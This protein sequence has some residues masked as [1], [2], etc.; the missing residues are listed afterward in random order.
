M[1]W[2]AVAEKDFR[3]A[4]RSRLLL[5]VAGLFVL[6]TVGGA[7]IGSALGMGG[8]DAVGLIMF[9]MLSATGIF[10][11]II[12]IGLSYR[13]IAGER[14]TGS[15]KI[16]LSLPNSRADVVLGKFAG[17]SAVLAVT[18]IV[19]FT[20][21]L[22]AFAAAFEGNVEFPTYAAFMLTTLLLGFVFVSITVG[23]SAFTNS[24][25]QSAVGAVGL[26]VVF[27]WLWNILAQIAWYVENGFE[28]PPFQA[29]PPDWLEF[30]YILNPTVSYR[31]A[32]SWLVEQVGN[33]DQAQQSGGLE[34]FGLEP[35]FGFVILAWW[36][37]LPLAIGY[38]RFEAT[39]L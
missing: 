12:A 10:V 35:W 33:S 19:G 34:P 9:V 2:M 15:L 14:D 31:Q 36:I 28:Q 17:R 6:F 32:T 29:E 8:G 16:L 37:A 26:F 23:V 25:F 7:A 5:V 11:P 24:T 30:L 1:S 39:D 18:V 22:V 3:D 27:Q 20:A 13:S 38:L 4:I 21:G